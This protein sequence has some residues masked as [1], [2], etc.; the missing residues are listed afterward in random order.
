MINPKFRNI[1]KPSVQLFKF[2]E[3]GS[4]RNSFFKHFMPLVEPKFLIWYLVRNHLWSTHKKRTKSVWKICQNVEKKGDTTIN[5]LEYLL[6]QFIKTR[7][8]KH[9][10]R[11]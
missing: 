3:N 2:G 9:F 5:V 4:T 11:N 6:H 1:N 7:K 8:C 10:S